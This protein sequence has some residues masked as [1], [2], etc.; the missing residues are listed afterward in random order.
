M[1]RVFSGYFV[2]LFLWSKSLVFLFHIYKRVFSQVSILDRLLISHWI[3][4]R[5]VCKPH[6]I[7]IT[8]NR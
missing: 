8:S 5:F 6:R 7:P 2:L 4:L 3:I 1:I